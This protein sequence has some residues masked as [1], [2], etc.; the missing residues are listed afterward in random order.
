MLPKTGEPGANWRSRRI[1]D[2]LSIDGDL[3]G[4]PVL[5][6]RPVEA[7]N[8]MVYD[9]SVRDHENFVC[10][11]GGLCAH[12]TDADVDGSHIRTLLLTF[13]YRYMESLVANGHLYI[14]QPPLYRVGVTR[15]ENGKAKKS[16]E[17]VYDD[18]ALENMR[19][20]RA[21][22][23][24]DRAAL[25]RPGRD[26]RRAALG[27]DHE[28]SQPH[29]AACANIDDA[30]EADRTFDMLMGS[31]VSPPAA[32]YPD[33]RQTG[34]L[35]HLDVRQQQPTG[36]SLDHL[37]CRFRCPSLVVQPSMFSHQ[38]DFLRYPP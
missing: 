31:N 26:E 14:A 36:R 19:K 34:A 28:P 23:V 15:Q 11:T 12:N 29:R 18:K 21:T 30:A 20:E 35:G 4:F 38:I 2:F 8:G 25:Q 22:Q 17:Y 5:S 7:S 1:G 9:F 37:H 27:N 24:T 13:F 16:T 3:V 33:A 6:V 32:L 10:G